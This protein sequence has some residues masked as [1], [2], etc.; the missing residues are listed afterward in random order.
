M[1]FPNYVWFNN[2]TYQIES[3]Y[4][5]NH[6]I[7]YYLKKNDIVT[8]LA[9]IRKGV[10]PFIKD[11]CNRTSLDIAVVL[12]MRKFNEF[13]FT[14][15]IID[16]LYKTKNK[17]EE[18]E[19]A[20]NCKGILEKYDNKTDY[21][22][23]D[24]FH[25]ND[26]K[27][28]DN[29]GMKKNGNCKMTHANYQDA[30]FIN[31]IL[32]QKKI[33]YNSLIIKDY[34]NSE[35]ISNEKYKQKNLFFSFQKILIL[36]LS[37]NMK[38]QLNEILRQARALLFFI[39]TLS[40][41]IILKKSA[42]NVIKEE[43]EKLP[44]PYFYNAAIHTLFKFFS[45]ERVKVKRKKQKSKKINEQKNH[46]SVSSDISNS[47]STNSSGKGEHNAINGWDVKNPADSRKLITKILT[48]Q[49]IGNE[50]IIFIGTFF[51][52]FSNLVFI[53]GEKIFRTNLITSQYL[54]HM[55]F[56]LDNEYLFNVII[57]RNNV[58]N[59]AQIFDWNKLIDSLLPQ[60]DLMQGYYKPLIYAK[61]S[62]SFLDKVKKF[63]QNK[64]KKKNIK[65][66]K[67]II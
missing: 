11:E 44:F 14:S 53:F 10:S 13:I 6:T 27:D 35:N 25:K 1:E 32:L 3:I 23:Y 15:L 55:S 42:K 31:S 20:Y 58:F 49:L 43:I 61:L 66:Y 40:K 36:N 56:T 62:K 5:K 51:S 21:N 34:N 48:N 50:I 28:M 67:K 18:V 29:V 7:H 57:N 45:P 46:S 65:K 38:A 64:N 16:Y 8:A 9:E 33:K 47:S 2:K 22:E 12:F 60:Q 26:N 19:Y 52:Y 39:K 41:N 30:N 4:R 59:Q 63:Y 17:N 24:I 37:K 54:L